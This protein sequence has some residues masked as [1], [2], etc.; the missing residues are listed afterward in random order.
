M[1]E[2]KKLN[3]EII[4]TYIGATKDNLR[5][6]AYNHWY[7]FIEFCKRN[8]GKNWKEDIRAK[9][10]SWIGVDFRYLDDYLMSCLSWGIMELNDGNLIFKGIPDDAEMPCEL[11]EEQLK[12]ELAEENEQRNKLGKPRVSLEE[13]KEKRSKRLKP[14]K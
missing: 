6:D 10:R 11:T 2:P 8:S 4:L 9:L 13:W 7:R 12:E 5:A 14:I 1:S 3:T